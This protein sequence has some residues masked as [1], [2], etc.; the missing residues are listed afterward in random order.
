V[1]IARDEPEMTSVATITPVAELVVAAEPA[2][3]VTAPSEP[4][5]LDTLTE[6]PDK[7]SV[8]TITPLA[9]D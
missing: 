1:E 9:D 7:T 3:G 8:W 2:S 6:E 4:L 5:A